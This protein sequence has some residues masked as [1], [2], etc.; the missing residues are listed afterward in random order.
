MRGDAAW[1]S[2]P[3]EL[4]EVLVARAGGQRRRGEGAA[5]WRGPPREVAALRGGRERGE[6]AGRGWVGGR[7]SG[8]LVPR[9][10]AGRGCGA[11]P[12]PAPSP[13]SPARGAGPG[14]AGRGGRRASAGPGA[15]LPLPAAG[16][17]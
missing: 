3:G 12:A 16:L 8:R 15:P 7:A 11:A 17:P 13:L 10:P 6:A 9:G 1:P 4:G 5:G 2:Q 14:R